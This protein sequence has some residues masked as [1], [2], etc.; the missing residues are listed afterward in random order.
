MDNA[1]KAAIQAFKERKQ[2]RG[3]FAVRCRTT[4]SVWVDSSLD[5]DA[6]ENRTF[7]LARV[8]DVQMDKSIQAEYAAHGQEAFNF[9]VLEK[10]DQDT[11]PMAVKDLLRERKRHWLTQANARPLWPL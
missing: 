4:G 5:L 8:G 11:I 7:F 2:A 6:A 1:R 9:E 3:I 10:L